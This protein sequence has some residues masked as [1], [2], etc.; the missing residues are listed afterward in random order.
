M[1]HEA[2]PSLKLG[3]DGINSVLL[4]LEAIRE[5]ALSK[6]RL[7]YHMFPIY[8]FFSS[9]HAGLVFM[10]STA[11]FQDFLKYSTHSNNFLISISSDVQG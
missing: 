6:P 4:T 10:H 9:Q 11:S 5:K 2:H 8:L 7:F 3:E 1:I